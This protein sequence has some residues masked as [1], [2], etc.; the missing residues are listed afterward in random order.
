MWWPSIGKGRRAAHSTRTPPHAGP[1]WADQWS[2]QG[3]ARLAEPSSRTAS[4][5]SATRIVWSTIAISMVAGLLPI[6]LL[7][8]F[9]P[10][11]SPRESQAITVLL[12]LWVLVV[13]I[14]TT[15]ILRRVLPASPTVASSPPSRVEKILNWTA[16]LLSLL[17]FYAAAVTRRSIPLWL[18]VCCGVIMALMTVL[19]LRSLPRDQRSRIAGTVYG[20][21]IVLAVLFPVV[22]VPRRFHSMASLLVGIVVTAMLVLEINAATRRRK[23]P[24][25]TDPSATP[26]S[27]RASVRMPI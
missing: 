19:A 26:G 22:T 16:V 14:A 1:S 20:M 8:I 4:D 17:A 10:H 12:M 21:I 2:V 24:S 18:W 13:A 23:A 3:A 15:V 6:F 27:A 11:Q 9:L 7:P 5:S 25:L